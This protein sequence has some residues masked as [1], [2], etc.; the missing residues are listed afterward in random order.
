MPCFT[1]ASR[2]G[3]LVAALLACLAAVLPAAA[4]AAGPRVLV[5]L[6]GP[7]GAVVRAPQAVGARDARLRV[8]RRFCRVPGAS[9][10]AALAQLRL[11]LHLT[12]AGGCAP[13]ALFVTSIA[14][15]ANRGRDGWAYKVGR[16]AGT[17]GAAGPSGSF[18]DGRR[19][20]GGDVVT[21]F[22][23]VLGAR[24]CQRTLGARRVGRRTV[25]V[26]GYDDAGRGVRV[27]G[28][29]VT[30][31]AGGRVAR[32]RTG[33]RG[34]ARLPALGGA[35]RISASRAGTVPALPGGAR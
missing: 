31:R 28:A 22:W 8:E 13:S 26:T 24:G 21:W 29:L 6:V 19:L 2:R 5:A 16:R 33:R 34:D 32:A 27:R 4:G 18:G 25:R 11:A 20:Q 17:A 7:G 23:C 10:L 12:A 9:P 14:G 15:R 3:G 35:W 30:V 1:S